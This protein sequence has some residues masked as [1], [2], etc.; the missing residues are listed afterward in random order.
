MLEALR[1]CEN[2]YSFT[3][4]DDKS[5]FPMLFDA[6]LD[7]LLATSLRELTIRSYSDLGPIVWAKLNTMRGLR[8]VAVWCMEGPPQ[9]LQGWAGLLGSTLT[10]LELGVR[11]PAPSGAPAAAQSHS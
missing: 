6:F 11:R 5:S 7:I 2:I 4:V 8:K 10:E 3:W 1:L 9:I